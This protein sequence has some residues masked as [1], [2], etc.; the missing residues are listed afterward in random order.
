METKKK[1]TVKVEKVQKEEPKIF[2]GR[3]ITSIG[4]RKRSVAQVRIYQNGKG[5][6][7]INEKKAEEYFDQ[8][9]VNVINQPLKQAG[10]VKDINISVRVAGGGTR[11][12]A[13]AI[14]HGITQALV[15]MNLEL[16][17]AMKAKGWLTRDSRK[18]ERKKPGLKK[19][20]R[21]PQWS[22]R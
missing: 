7:E 12:Q 4:R 3:F 19:A 16:R 14:R 22:K 13:D 21:A 8:L 9:A 6:I 17:P 1:T 20:R 18:K 10:L 5:L 2:K 11:G 15:K